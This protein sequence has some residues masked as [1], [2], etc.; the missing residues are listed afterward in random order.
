MHTDPTPLSMITRLS[1]AFGPSGFEDDVLAVA[2]DYAQGLGDIE[3]DCLRNLYI[4]RKENTGNKPVIML[5]AHSDEVGFMVHSIKPNGTLR[6]VAIGGWRVATLPGSQVLVRT[7][8]GDYIPGIVASKPVHFMTS[9]E[10]HGHPDSAIGDLII[11]IGARSAQ[12][13]VEDFRIRIGEPI[14]PF[15]RCSYDEKLDVLFGKAFDCRIGC[16]ALLEALRRLEGEE[17]PCDVI[18]V[19]SSQEEVGDRGV[20]VAVNR[21]KPDLAIVL[22]G[23][24]ADDTFTEPYAIQTALKKGPMFRHMDRSLVCNPRFQR[25]VLDLAREK[26]LPVQESVRSGGG[27]NA[28]AVQT[29]HLGA[30]AVVAGVPVRYVHAPNCMATGFDLEATVQVV[31]EI[32]KT[33]TPERIASF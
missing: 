8:D 13:A 22:E 3:E 26:G 10:R 18:G 7:R 16:A 2:R 20:Q 28:A 23:C 12:E 6:F 11:D 5:D 24:P 27:N 17:L 15:T 19:F 33:L 25:F 21:V 32:L 9:A 29:E 14:V 30:P 1:D 4:H 31:I